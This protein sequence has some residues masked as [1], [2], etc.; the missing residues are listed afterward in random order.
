MEIKA[1]ETEYNGYRFRSRAEARW[2]IA[3][4]HLGIEY[5]YEPEGYQLSDGTKYLPDF[6]L[7]E[8]KTY[9]E[10]KGVMTGKDMHKITQLQ[11]DLGVNIAIGYPDLT[12]QASDN[13]AENYYQINECKEE[14]WLMKCRECGKYFFTGDLGTWM[15]QCCGYYD[16]DNTAE[17]VCAGD[18]KSWYQEIG[19]KIFREARQARFEHG[20]KPKV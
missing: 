6:Y 15:C 5:M 11:K 7:P 16:G 2:A 9:F 4:E 1:I 12:F 8:S 10:V 19:A 3:F 13:W 17:W 18:H 20:E 14:S